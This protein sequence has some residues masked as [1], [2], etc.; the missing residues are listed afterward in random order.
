MATRNRAGLSLSPRS[1]SR[2]CRQ[3]AGEVDVEGHPPVLAALAVYEQPAGA[4]VD[5]DDVQGQHLARSQPA[6]EH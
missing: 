3:D 5:V 2:Y 4:D 1:V 6:V